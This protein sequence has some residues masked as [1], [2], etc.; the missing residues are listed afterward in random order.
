MN[1]IIECLGKWEVKNGRVGK[2]YSYYFM[3]DRYKFIIRKG[4]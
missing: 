1:N 3:I 2:V 4:G